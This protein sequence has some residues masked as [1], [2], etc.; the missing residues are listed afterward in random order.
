[1]LLKVALLR[2]VFMVSN[3]SHFHIAYINYLGESLI[4]SLHCICTYIKNEEKKQIH[5]RLVSG[6]NV[7]TEF[8][9]RG[10]F[11]RQ[12]QHILQKVTNFPKHSKFSKIFANV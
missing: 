4:F 10:E 8:I 11:L 9:W 2:N 5:P 1:M 6:L 3:Y 12:I 7:Y